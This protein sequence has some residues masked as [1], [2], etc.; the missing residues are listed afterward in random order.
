MGDYLDK[1]EIQDF[2]IE[3]SEEEIDNACKDE[4]ESTE[5]S[6]SK[7]TNKHFSLK[8]GDELR[9]NIV[10]RRWWE[11]DMNYLFGA[12]DEGY[13]SSIKGFASILPILRDNSSA[14]RAIVY[15][16]LSFIK[17]GDDFAV[18][19]TSTL[20]STSLEDYYPKQQE[21]AIFACFDP[22]NP[23][24]TS[25]RG[26]EEAVVFLGKYVLDKERSINE[27]YFVFKLTDESISVTTCDTNVIPESLEKYIIKEL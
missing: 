25:W 5:L 15:E 16:K 4:Y 2:I 7:N 8:K 13:W 22:K 19:T 6:D 21:I 14:I 23:N 9:C 18:E 1:R 3:Q 26:G 10:K 11:E 12:E 17:T 20:N 24:A 27:G